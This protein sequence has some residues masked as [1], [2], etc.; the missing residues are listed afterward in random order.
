MNTIVGPTD[1]DGVFAVIDKCLLQTMITEHLQSTAHQEIPAHQ[2]KTEAALARSHGMSLC[3]K[4]M[5]LGLNAKVKEK[6]KEKVEEKVE[7]KRKIE[8]Q[9]GAANLKSCFKSWAVDVKSCFKDSLQSYF[10]KVACTINTHKSPVKIRLLHT[11]AGHS[12]SGLSA[13]ADKLIFD[14]NKSI[15]HLKKDSG[16]VLKD[17][18][19]TTYPPG[20]F[21]L[22]MDIKD[23]Y[24]SGNHQTIIALCSKPFTG[25]V[26]NFIID[27]LHY[28]LFYQVLHDNGSDTYYKVIVG[29]GM[30][31]KASGTLSD[32]VF[33]CLA[34]ENFIGTSKAIDP[35]IITYC[36]FRDDILAILKSY[37]TGKLVF[38]ELSNRASR[39]Y[40]L[41][42]ESISLVGTSFLDCFIFK[43]KNFE[44]HGKMSWQPHIKDTARHVP[45]HCSSN[46]PKGVHEAWPVTEIRR[47]H[48]L[49]VSKH[50]FLAFR[51]LKI[52]RFASFYMPRS[53]LQSCYRWTPKV[54]SQIAVQHNNFECSSEPRLIRVVVPYHPMLALGLNRALALVCKRWCNDITLNCGQMFTLMAT[55]SNAGTALQYAARHERF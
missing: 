27:L 45:L 42:R 23:F 20:G 50:Q 44:D 10:Y 22:K 32:Y 26:K 13:V 21:F 15:P 31:A 40:V 43:P 8:E 28:F 55:Y 5:K 49:S 35:G 34:E 54:R 29:T 11:A 51:E 41:E 25:E 14:L 18:G 53:I 2:A 7:E 16:E 52:Q 33:Y 47:M 17:I 46:H 4:L 6:D 48:R 19:A 1:K 39:C 9:E 38:D 24:M 12:L 3:N 36:R 37:H 30:G